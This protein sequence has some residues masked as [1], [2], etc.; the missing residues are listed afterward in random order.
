MNKIL[1]LALALGLIT[2]TAQAKE[3]FYNSPYFW[4]GVVGGL[5]VGEVIADRHHEHRHKRH[6]H[7]VYED[8]PEC[9]MY[10]TR[11]WVPDRGY[12]PYQTVVCDDEE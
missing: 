11:V 7:H 8:E 4:G 10:H 1:A 3:R 5:V 12:V 2:S 9:Y 6:Y